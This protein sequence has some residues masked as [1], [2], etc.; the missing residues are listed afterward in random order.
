MSREIGYEAWL[1][2]L[3]LLMGVWQMMVYDC[4]RV[5]R[6]MLRHNSFWVGVEL[7]LI[8]I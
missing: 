3:S 8:H 7:S 4:L 2:L 5:L 6:L 1:L